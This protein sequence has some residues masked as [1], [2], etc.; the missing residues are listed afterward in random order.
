MFTKP[1]ELY[2][3]PRWG[4]ESDKNVCSLGSNGRIC[5]RDKADRTMIVPSECA[6]KD[7]R[8]GFSAKDSM[9]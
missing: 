1:L 8:D 2:I 9:W 5:G 4:P 7:I 3:V 6:T